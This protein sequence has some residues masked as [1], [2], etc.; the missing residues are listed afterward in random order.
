MHV[1]FEC[2]IEKIREIRICSRFFDPDF[3]HMAALGARPT[4]AT[5]S[6]KRHLLLVVH[7]IHYTCGET[8]KLLKYADPVQDSTEKN[9]LAE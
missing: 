2:G 5:Q 6:T 8:I 7:S 4:G 9:C 3:S 1:P